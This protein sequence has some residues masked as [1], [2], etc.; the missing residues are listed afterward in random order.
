[1]TVQKSRR[2]DDVVEHVLCGIA[3]AAVSGIV[4]I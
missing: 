3:G 1:M 4:L 2:V